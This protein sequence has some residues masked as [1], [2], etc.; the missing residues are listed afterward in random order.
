MDRTGKIPI[1]SE[2]PRDEDAECHDVILEEEILKQK[3]KKR[4]CRRGG[5]K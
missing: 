4:L 5:K 2:N 1:P 3:L